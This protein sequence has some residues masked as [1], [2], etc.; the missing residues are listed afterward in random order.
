MS[1]VVCCVFMNVNS[2]LIYVSCIPYSI[3][4]SVYFSLIVILRNSEVV[5]NR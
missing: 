5:D 2:Y 3:E 1:Y 4:L